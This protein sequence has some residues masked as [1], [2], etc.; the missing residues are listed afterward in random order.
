[1][2]NF[3]ARLESVEAR[4]QVLERQNRALRA[5]V[6]I[7]VVCVAAT[8]AVAAAS[9]RTISAEKLILT[10]SSGHARV[11]LGEK[12]LYFTGPSGKKLAN[13]WADPKTG[14]GVVFFD[15]KGV[16]GRLGIGMWGKDAGI[17]IEKVGGG[18][19]AWFGQQTYGSSLQLFDAS[20]KK[21]LSAEAGNDSSNFNVFGESGKPRAQLYIAKNEAGVGVNDAAGF[22]RIIA[23]MSDAPH[24]KLYDSGGGA[25]WS[26]P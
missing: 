9:P 4:L 22:A 18:E 15:G 16:E 23:S 14:S 6:A 26:A 19:M 25:I 12:G 3:A 5:S 17:G 7:G 2:E 10:D 8:L 11:M 1:M 24:V 13:F 20:G 21:R